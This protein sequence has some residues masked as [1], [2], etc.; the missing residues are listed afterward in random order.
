MC[1]LNKL[2]KLAERNAELRK[3]HSQL[4]HKLRNKLFQIEM[5]LYVIKRDK[6][7]RKQAEATWK[8]S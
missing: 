8:H 5:R 4:M 2:Q 3:I 7:K 1:D 6:A